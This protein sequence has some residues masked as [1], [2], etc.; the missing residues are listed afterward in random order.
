MREDR[1]AVI[2][3][4]LRAGLLWLVFLGLVGLSV[5]LAYERHWEGYW[6]MIPWAAI[7]IMFL[8]MLI[9]VIWPAPATRK[10]TK[11]VAVL[12]ILVACLGVWLHFD[13]NYKTAS[14]DA[15][16]TERWESMSLVDRVWE[17]A[18]GSVG[19]VPIYAAGL[20]VPLG[21][22]LAV[23]SIGMGERESPNEYIDPRQRG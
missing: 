10:L 23:A 11:I 12:M 21:L 4:G 8:T 15:N 7:G 13:E 2:V 19:H 17:V 20:L 18:K 14:L 22:A 16:Y 5:A 3:S 1:N 6:Q 9:L